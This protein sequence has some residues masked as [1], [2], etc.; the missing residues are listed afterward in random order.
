MKYIQIRKQ[1]VKLKLSLLENMASLKKQ[2]KR[3][4]G[5]ILW[6]K[7]DLTTQEIPCFI[8]PSITNEKKYRENYT[9]FITIKI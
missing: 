8:T 9:S 5:Q 6:A 2:I 4:N 3:I 1:Q 7:R